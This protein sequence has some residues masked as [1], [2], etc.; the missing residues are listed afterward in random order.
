M[1]LLVIQLPPTPLTAGS[2][3][4]REFTYVQSVDGRT[5]DRVSCA[6]AHQLPAATGAGSENI[7]VVP[8]TALS[9]HRIEWPRGIRATSPRLR[10]ALEGLLEE[11]LLD[12]P[13]MMHFAL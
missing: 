1:R 2:E 3:L 6:P 13:E 8:A 4:T 11:H 10:A 5:A 12:E 7:A 9:W